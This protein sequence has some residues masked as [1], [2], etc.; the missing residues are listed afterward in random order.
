MLVV[1]LGLGARLVVRVKQG[2]QQVDL[3]AT[4]PSRQTLGQL[5]ELLSEMDA[6]REQMDLEDARR[7][8]TAT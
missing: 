5:R 3:H 4:A 7:P 6:W 1:I 2:Q 8:H